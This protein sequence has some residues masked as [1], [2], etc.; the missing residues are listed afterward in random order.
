MFCFSNFVHSFLIIFAL[1]FLRT[2]CVCFFDWWMMLNNL[3][4]VVAFCLLLWSLWEMIIYTRRGRM[5]ITFAVYLQTYLPRIFGAAGNHLWAA[6]S[7]R[8]RYVMT[9]MTLAT[10]FPLPPR[11][12]LQYKLI[13]WLSHLTICHNYLYTSWPRFLQFIS[14]KKNYN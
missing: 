8:I 11:F 14:K 5:R 4:W 9:H 3:K 2:D 10:C 6:K 12:F 7:Q 13:P 1:H